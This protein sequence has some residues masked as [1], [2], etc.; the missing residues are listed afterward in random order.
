M[1]PRELHCSA[2]QQ[3]TLQSNHLFCGYRGISYHVSAIIQMLE[4]RTSF[5]PL[6]ARD[7]RNTVRR[8]TRRWKG[9]HRIVY[10]GH[11]STL[12]MCQLVLGF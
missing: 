8:I 9:K 10:R 1:S 5:P 6:S 2:S 7:S 11:V 4:Q 3:L 12:K